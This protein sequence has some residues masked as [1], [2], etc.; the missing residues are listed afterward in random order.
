ML[1]VMP[2]ITGTMYA[3]SP[4]KDHRDH[5]SCVSVTMT[6]VFD[7]YCRADV[8]KQFFAYLR[9]SVCALVHA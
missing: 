1:A 9:N 7:P 4:D 6:I 2:R 5:V 8:P 3:S